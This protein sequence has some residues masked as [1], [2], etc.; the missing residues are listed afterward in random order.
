MYLCKFTENPLSIMLKNCIQCTLKKYFFKWI[1]K[2]FKSVFNVHV[3]LKRYFLMYIE[4]T[5]WNGVFL[6]QYTEIYLRLPIL[7]FKKMRRWRMIRNFT[8]N[9]RDPVDIT[10]IAVPFSEKYGI[11]FPFNFYFLTSGTHCITD[12]HHGR[13]WCKPVC[14]SRTN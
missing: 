3:P 8:I 5:Y 14:N 9:N 7:I 1:F 11:Q 10:N 6:L 2:T 4:Y 12:H 13:K